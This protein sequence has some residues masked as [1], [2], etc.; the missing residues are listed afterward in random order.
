MLS[1]P[2]TPSLSLDQLR[3]DATRLK[4]AFARG[5]EAVRRRM[6]LVLPPA[7]R[8]APRH[9]DFLHLVALEHHFESWPRLVAAAE[10]Q[11]LN[12][13]SAQQRLKVALF[14][15]QIPVAERLLAQWPDLAEGLF[16]LMCALYDVEGVARMLAEDPA[17]AARIAGPRRPILHLAFSRW[18]KAR[19]D[20]SEQMLEVARL[21]VRHGADVNDH[22]VPYPGSTMQL[23]AL[24]GAIGHT[25]NLTLGAWLL[26][27][28]ANPNDGES[29]YHATELGH[30]DGLRLLLD[31]GADP[32]GTNALL[33]AMDFNDHAA[34]GMLLAHG[35]D[36]SEAGVP[37]PPLHQAARR[38][39]DAAMA[40]L[41]LD[42]G[43]DPAQVWR[44]VSA[45]ALARIHGARDVAGALPEVSLTATEQRL[46]EAAE[47]RATGALCAEDLP[48]ACQQLMQEVAARPSGLPHLQALVALGL[49]FDT[50]DQDGV[51]PVQMA[52]WE[53]LPETMGWLITQGVDLG[54]LNGHGGTLIGTILHGAE[55]CPARDS[56][57]HQG[58]LEVA[59]NAGAA[60]ARAEIANTG[61]EDLRAVMTDWAEAHPVS[62]L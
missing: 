57:D 4:K 14:R 54:H 11:G 53:G 9:A 41:M 29:L 31:H 19:P 21:L 36:V 52:G 27:H 43:A 35:A 49:P 60:L 55:N 7:R 6:Q 59:L 18:I 33:R 39:C 8:K 16:G 26:D 20:L 28:G 47:G 23:S 22:F 46:A 56:R 25:D 61:R 40:R 34:V 38:H 24:Y 1:D 13:A 15:G 2:A 3:R 42:A 58:C 12:R 10:T 37:I 48:K 45:Y 17:R 30:T 32:K 51:P 50:P 5:D 44:G 62:V